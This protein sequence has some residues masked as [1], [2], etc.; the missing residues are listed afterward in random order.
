MPKKN[1]AG[2]K[3]EER[4]LGVHVT[5]LVDR[6]LEFYS[7]KTTQFTNMLLAMEAIQGICRDGHRVATIGKVNTVLCVCTA[8][9][10]G[11]R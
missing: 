8:A 1:A 10:R 2:L 11:S 9:L 3:I 4:K 6:L 5:C 7:D